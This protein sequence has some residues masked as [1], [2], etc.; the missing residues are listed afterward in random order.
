MDMESLE[1]QERARLLQ[2]RFGPQIENARQEL[3]DLNRKVTTFIKQNPTTCILGALA[4]GF[5][6]GKI[7]SR[8]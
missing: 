4:V 1:M 6:V 7:A 2:E 5:I 8:R 3:T